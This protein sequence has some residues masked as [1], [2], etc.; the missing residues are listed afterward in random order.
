M[1]G[2]AGI[3]GRMDSP[4]VQHML[5]LLAHRG[6]DASGLCVAL[7]APG[8]VGHRRLSIMDPLAG[9]QPIYSADQTQ[10]IIANGEIYNFPQL[11]PWLAERHHFRTRSDSEAILHLYAEC[12]MAAVEHL[13]GMY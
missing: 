1:C 10:A 13:Q 7:A 4:R 8:V 5:D 6:P 3:W 9:D 2:I 12:G 11:Q